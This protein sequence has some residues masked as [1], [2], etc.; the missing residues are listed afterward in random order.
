MAILGSHLVSIGFTMGLARLYCSRLQCFLSLAHS[1]E[2]GGSSPEMCQ[3]LRSSKKLQ[4]ECFSK[5]FIRVSRGGGSACVSSPRR[6]GAPKSFKT[7]AFSKLFALI[8]Q[9]FFNDLAMRF[10]CLFYAFPLLVQ[11]FFNA[12]GGAR[13]TTEFYN[14]AAARGNSQMRSSPGNG[15][16]PGL[17]TLACTWVQGNP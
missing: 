16:P 15:L 12:F 4:N 3:T 7:I 11:C 13:Y 5:L 14:A 1:G 10:A 2:G 17:G 6:S 8:F 9:C